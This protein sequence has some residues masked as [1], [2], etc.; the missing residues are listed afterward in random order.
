MLIVILLFV[1]ALVAWAL[2]LMQEAVT[3]QEFSLMLAGTL[4]A[5]AAAGLV[6]VYCIMGNYMGFITRMDR[7]PEVLEQVYRSVQSYLEA[8]SLEASQVYLSDSSTTLSSN[9]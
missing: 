3:R 7:D 4:V 8:E 9:P 6:S 1:I 5:S 2:H